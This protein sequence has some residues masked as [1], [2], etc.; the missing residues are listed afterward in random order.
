MVFR[1]SLRMHPAAKAIVFCV[2]VL[3]LAWLT[4]RAL[5]DQRGANPAGVGFDGTAATSMRSTGLSIDRSNCARSMLVPV[6]GPVMLS[7][8]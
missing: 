6:M 8:V 5:G 2:C 4:T 1:Q 7:A 3:P